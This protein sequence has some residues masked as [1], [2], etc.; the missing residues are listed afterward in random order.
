VQELCIGSNQQGATLANFVRNSAEATPDRLQVGD[1][2]ELLAALSAIRLVALPDKNRTRQL[3]GGIYVRD[4]SDSL[5]LPMPRSR[6]DEAC[7]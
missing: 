6:A 2:V 3:P 4:A 5:I 7:E 1:P